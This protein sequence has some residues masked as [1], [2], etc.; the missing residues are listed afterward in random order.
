MYILSSNASLKFCFPR[1]SFFRPNFTLSSSSSFFDISDRKDNSDAVIVSFIN[2]SVLES[3]N[4]NCVMCNFKHTKMD[5]EEKIY[6]EIMNYLVTT[7]YNI[8]ATTIGEPFLFKTDMLK[9]LIEL[10]S[11]MYVITNGTLLDEDYIKELSKYKDKLTITLSIDSLNKDLYEQIRPFAKFEKIFI[12]MMLL[13]KY[14]LLQNVNYTVQELNLDSCKSDLDWFKKNN[15][16]VDILAC[17]CNEKYK[18]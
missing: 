14:G 8:Q 18:I 15:I 11:K 13:K 2:N 12:N 7:D 3:C 5:I 1:V 6:K 4:L 10:K 17:D 16:R 9:W